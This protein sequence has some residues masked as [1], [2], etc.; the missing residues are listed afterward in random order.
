MLLKFNI[1]IQIQ[2]LMAQI[3]A[4][5]LSSEAVKIILKYESN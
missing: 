2:F 5:T 4:H 3:L 1:T